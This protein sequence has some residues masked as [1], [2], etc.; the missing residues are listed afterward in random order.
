MFCECG[1]LKELHTIDGCCDVDAIP[2]G[3]SECECHRFYGG[4][5]TL[6]EQLDATNAQ[7][8]ATDEAI[9]DL[10][11]AMGKPIPFPSGQVR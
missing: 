10:F 5:M 11:T 3:V 6:R 8:A 7:Q 2:G 9:N 1:H 4:E